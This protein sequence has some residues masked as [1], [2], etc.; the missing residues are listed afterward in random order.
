MKMPEAVIF[1]YQQK[2][3]TVYFTQAKAMLPVK[4]KSGEVK[5]VPWGRRENENSEMPLGGWARLV[6][7]K[8]EKDNRWH[9]YLPKPVQIPVDKFME[10]N[11]EGQRC[12]YEIT[13]GKCLQ[14]LLANHDNE[15]RLYIVTIDPEDLMNCHYRWPHIITSSIKSA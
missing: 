8:N 1:Y 2:T 3:Y 11:H 14:G 5:L 9:L 15:Y 4:L 12:W 7:I 6:S 10:K 13:K